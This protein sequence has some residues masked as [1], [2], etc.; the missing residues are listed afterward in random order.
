MTYKEIFADYIQ[1]INNN[2]HTLLNLKK[3]VSTDNKVLYTM[4]CLK[5]KKHFA[6]FDH[7]TNIIFCPHCGYN[8]SLVQLVANITNT[9]EEES[10]YKILKQKLNYTN[11]D[12][13][14]LIKYIN[15][16]NQNYSILYEVN[17]KAMELYIEDFKTNVMAREY[18]INTRKLN[19]ETLSYFCIGS[20]SH[21][22]LILDNLSSTYGIDVLF[23]AGLVGYNEE[24][25]QY[26]DFF[27]NRLM[28]PIFDE[29]HRVIGFGGRTL[30][31]SAAK[32]L[33]T[34]STPIFHKG[35]TLYAID[36]LEKGVLYDKV[37]ITEGYM[38][39]V[40][41]HQYGITNVTGN[42]GTAI[43]QNH[44]DLLS[45]Y[46]IRPVVM[47]DGD[48]A[49]VNA[50]KRTIEKVGKVDT[51]ILPNNLDPDEYLREY[52]SKSLINTINKNIKS[53]NEAMKTN[54]LEKEGNIFENFLSV[55]GF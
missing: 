42:L 39:V 23:E 12:L 24:K 38:D 18:A 35:K 31:S 26:Y 43:T 48:L 17:Q 7:K 13:S 20:S 14:S 32:Y 49:G 33:N 47:L 36:K 3:I 50:M 27:K 11:S 44:L 51:V 37:L 30:T 5:N 52:S 1:D 29:F 21:K 41:M 46:T 10:L 16:K 25:N 6:Y 19:D 28:F 55:K 9:T 45:K 54:L 15:E 4:N 34:K 8:C 40:T 22:N 2:I 53:W